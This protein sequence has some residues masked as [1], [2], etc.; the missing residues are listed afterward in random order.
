MRDVTHHPSMAHQPT[1]ATAPTL[2]KTR[3]LVAV[4]G[5]VSLIAA[6]GG[7]G[8]DDS[9]KPVEQGP[10]AIQSCEGLQGLS[11]PS[12]SIGLPTRGATVLSAT[13]EAP[14]APYTDA[15]GEHLLTTPS[16]CVVQGT[17][18]S[19]DGVAPAI[20]FAINLPL[21]NW[22]TR[23]L[24]SGGGGLGGQVITAPGNKASGRFDPMP[25][26]VPY[27]IT[28]GYVTL[29]SDGG[30]AGTDFLHPRNDEALANWA[31]DHLKKTRDV[32]MEVVK[33][34]YGRS[35]S[36]IFFAGES[37][38]GRESL[39]LA[40][41]YASDYDGYIATSPVLSWNYLMLASNRLRD[42]LISG[43]LDTAA[44]KLVADQTRT[45]C[46]ALD[47]IADGV[48]A[49]YMECP[50]N[51]AALRCPDGLAATGCL[52]TAQIDSVRALREPFSMPV[53][54]AHGILRFP[55]FS[56]TGDEDGGNYQWPFYPVGTVAPSLDLAT[57]R[58]NEAGRGALMNFATFWVRHVIVQN[59]SY[60]PYQF[61]PIPY[62]SRIQKLSSLFDATNPDLSA[63]H[64]RG[65]KVIIVHPSADNATPLT[66][67]AEYYRSVVA[68]LG[69]QA[70]DN[71]LRL[72]VGPGGSHNVGGISQV[73]ALTIL[74]NWVLKGEAPPDAPT[75]Y[76]KNVTT[77]ATISSMPACRYPA[78]PKYNGSGDTKA[79]SSY[80]CTSRQDPL[81]APA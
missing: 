62:T 40:Q 69:Q 11:V 20:K 76:N 2:N 58:G 29:G 49:K 31:V 65:A 46:D 17:I 80:T 13:R 54:M 6:C 74:E 27:P 9:P 56:A 7:N 70:A 10:V 26:D 81:A 43:F 45:T 25:V 19:A 24:Q 8:S 36:K 5:S 23:M 73:D 72:Y 44:I 61:D 77:G 30:H 34:A 18:A 75:A 59:E 66:V 67:S 52:S 79:A 39:M 71:V 50:N 68:K 33:A 42:K 53:S 35:P 21:A 3:G 1:L 37:A 38:G 32:A 16:R 4:I 14:V 28:L 55:G 63:A 60:N 15:E 57:G 48:V 64:A 47:G 22:N 41:K 51:V 78:Y 12:S